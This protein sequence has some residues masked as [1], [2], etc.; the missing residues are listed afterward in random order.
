MVDRLSQLGIDRPYI[1]SQAL[2]A[3]C[4]QR[5]IP[6]IDGQQKVFL[7]THTLQEL[8]KTNTYDW[9]DWQNGLE[10]AIIN[11][12]ITRKTAEQFWYG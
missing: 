8:I 11:Q 2:T 1:S 5:L 3:V 6:T 9:E 7:K 4:Y 12:Q 10:Q